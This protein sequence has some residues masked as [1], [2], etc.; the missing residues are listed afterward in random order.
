MLDPIRTPGN[1]GYYST[2]V[3]GDGMVE[4]MFFPD[5]DEP[6]Q[7]VD[8]SATLADIAR[9][10][11]AAHKART[12]YR[13]NGKAYSATVH[14]YVPAYRAADGTVYLYHRW[15]DRPWRK[16]TEGESVSTFLPD[17]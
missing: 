15:T 7:F 12:E 8:R 2:A 16:R 4:T 6:A 13:A 11:V 1:G 3:V 5:T 14:K 17:D 9:E 10:H